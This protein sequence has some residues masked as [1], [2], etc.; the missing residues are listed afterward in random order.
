[1]RPNSEN[2][3]LAEARPKAGQQTVFTQDLLWNCAATQPFLPAE[4]QAKLANGPIGP[5]RTQ[6][7]RTA[8]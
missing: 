2:P 8:H 4:M 7:F 5:V 1:M 6:F 3:Y